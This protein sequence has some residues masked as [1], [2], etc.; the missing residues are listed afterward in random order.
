MDAATVQATNA[1]LVAG[2]GRTQ[3]NRY[4]FRTLA[5]RTQLRC[6]RSRLARCGR[7][8]RLTFVEDGATKKLHTE[9]GN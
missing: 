8:G 7:Q 9:I 6:Q 5:A 3:L 4:H 1:F 2:T